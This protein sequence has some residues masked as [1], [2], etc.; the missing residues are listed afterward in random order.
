MFGCC[1]NENTIDYVSKMKSFLS[2]Y[3]RL[4]LDKSNKGLTDSSEKRITNVLRDLLKMIDNFTCINL[5]PRGSCL[6]HIYGL[7]KIHKQ[8]V[9]QWSTH[10]TTKLYDD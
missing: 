10:P 3:M 1:S 4:K 9:P 7:R 2:D 8:G 5:R 6:P